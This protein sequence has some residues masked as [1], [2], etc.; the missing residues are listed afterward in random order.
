M[1]ELGHGTD[2]K[3]LGVRVR[4]SFD[5]STAVLLSHSTTFTSPH[6]RHGIKMPS[7]G[8]VRNTHFNMSIWKALRKHLGSVEVGGTC[9]VLIIIK[10]IEY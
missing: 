9:K 2:A 7:Q 5:S 3:A 8:L 4:A 6:L 1:L 10:Q